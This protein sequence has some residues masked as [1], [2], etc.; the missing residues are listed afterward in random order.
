MTSNFDCFSSIVNSLLLEVNVAFKSFKYLLCVHAHQSLISTQ[1]WLKNPIRYVIFLGLSLW[2]SL[3]FLF[4]LCKFNCFSATRYRNRSNVQM[5]KVKNLKFTTFMGYL[6]KKLTVVKI[7]GQSV[8]WY[9]FPSQKTEK[10][11]GGLNHPRSKTNS[12][13]R[14]NFRI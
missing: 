10:P 13:R 14:I 2:N 9:G 11:K 4:F 12:R 3:L 8:T 6:W 7:M 5:A 1:H